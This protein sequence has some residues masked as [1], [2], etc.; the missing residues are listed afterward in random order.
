MTRRHLCWAAGLV[1]LLAP[2]LA[3]AAPKLLVTDQEAGAIYDF[4]AQDGGDISA[5]PFATGLGGPVGICVGPDNQIYV[6]DFDGQQVTIATDGGD[7]SG[8]PAFAELPPGGAPLTP[9]GIWCSEQSIIAAVPAAGISAVLDITNGGSDLGQWGLHVVWADDPMT[10]F[11]APLALDIVRDSADDFFTSSTLG[12]YAAGPSANAMDPAAIAIGA[13]GENVV[14]LELVGT[15]LIGGSGNSGVIYDLTGATAV[16]TAA[17][18]A[19][20][21]TP[22]TGGVLGLLNAGD[23][24]VFAATY[25]GIYDI[26]N[27]G[28][29][30]A[31]TPIAT[32][33]SQEGLILIDMT[34]HEC[35]SND[36]CLDEDLCNGEEVCFQGRCGPPEEELDCDDGDVCTADMCDAIEGC[37]SEDIDGCCES[38]LDCAI[39]EVCDVGD[40][41]C[42][43]A[44][45]PTSGSSESDSDS[46]STTGDETGGITT[47]DTLGTSSTT[48]ASTTASTST[49]AGPTTAGGSA[50][51]TEG[52]TDT[53]GAG[54]DDDADGCSC[55]A[56]QD[57]GRGLAFVGLLALCGIATRRRR[58]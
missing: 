42:V 39:D 49:T 43:P 54:A 26:T 48:G 44:S 52:D 23:Q 38:D 28:D 37:S 33:L 11:V 6:A 15:Q 19:T 10:M 57:P 25:D 29:L 45:S 17:V 18:F 47:D 53:D 4:T 30:T 22:T 1:A 41:E 14:P 35:G 51:D 2:S 27:G 31:A 16:D 7:L 5:S 34:Y 50:S 56:G 3:D 12:V 20:L 9:A 36:D 40:N 8:A 55:D 21:P 58:G 32:G 24:G 13:G 46:D